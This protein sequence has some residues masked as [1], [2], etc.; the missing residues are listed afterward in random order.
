[1]GHC[2]MIGILS[3]NY[4]GLGTASAV[5][6]LRRLVI[7]EHP[8]LLFLSE[9]RLKDFEMENVKNKLKFSNMLTIGC[10]REGRRRSGWIA[11]SLARSCS[12]S[13]GVILH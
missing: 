2:S 1:M 7:I 5:N 10:E 13:R 4:R 9:T 3:W 11:L 8:Q 12:C 6:A